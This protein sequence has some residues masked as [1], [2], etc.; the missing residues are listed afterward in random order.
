MND[1]SQRRS[2]SATTATVDIRVSGLNSGIL[3]DPILWTTSSP[4]YDVEQTMP[5]Y[6]PHGKTISS[7][8]FE[9]TPSQDF[10]S[11]I[12]VVFTELSHG[13]ESL[14]AK[15]EAVWDQYVDELYEP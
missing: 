13:Q 2:I 4:L 10:S 5:S 9:P 6:N 12:A 3:A 14:G 15:F 7:A 1:I 11:D 8:E